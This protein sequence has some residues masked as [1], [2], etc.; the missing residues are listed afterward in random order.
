MLGSY[1][2]FAP[3][4]LALVWSYSGAEVPSPLQDQRTDQDSD[5]VNECTGSES[6]LNGHTD[7]NFF[8][9]QGKTLLGLPWWSSG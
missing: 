2:S 9:H 7:L 3:D 8:V 5:P 4:R 6:Y 1:P